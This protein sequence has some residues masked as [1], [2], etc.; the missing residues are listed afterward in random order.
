MDITSCL[1]EDCNNAFL[2]DPKSD[3]LQKDVE[4]PCGKT[5]KNGEE[6]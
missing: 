4:I 3:D 5:L 6:F 2:N 1:C